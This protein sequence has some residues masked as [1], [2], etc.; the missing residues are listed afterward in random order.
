VQVSHFT[1]AKR[2]K[3]RWRCR[4]RHAPTV[5]TF[6]Q[7]LPDAHGTVTGPFYAPAVDCC[8]TPPKAGGA[9]G[10]PMSG[11]SAVEQG[12]KQGNPS[13]GRLH[14]SSLGLGGDVN[15]KR[16]LAAELRA[17]PGIR[18]VLLN[19]TCGTLSVVYHRERLS[20]GDVRAAYARRATAPLCSELARAS[21][22]SKWWPFS[23]RWVP[24]LTRV[25][26]TLL[27]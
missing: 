10:D 3:W 17:M 14:F 16:L 24:L 12:N 19:R 25:M 27:G 13:F 8:D 6:T 23:L 22:G 5:S 2:L 4:D 9:S 20:A 1:Y 21:G 15:T 26:L 11:C 7:T 18:S